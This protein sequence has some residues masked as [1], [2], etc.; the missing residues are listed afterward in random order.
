[1]LADGVVDVLLASGLRPAR[2][3]PG[4]SRAAKGQAVDQGL[5]LERLQ[6]GVLLAFS[7]CI[8]EDLDGVE[9]HVGRPGRCT[10][11]WAA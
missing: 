6:I 11:R 8:C 9:A 4:A 3:N 10:S 7:I 5:P 1:M 2:R